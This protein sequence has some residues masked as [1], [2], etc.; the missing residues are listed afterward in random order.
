MRA[1]LIDGWVYK[2]HKPENNERFLIANDL[3][4]F[5]GLKPLEYRLEGTELSCR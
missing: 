5:F 1:K 2:N 4:P 3:K